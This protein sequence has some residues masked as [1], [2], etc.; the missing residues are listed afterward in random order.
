MND[1]NDPLDDII[2][3]HLRYLEGEGPA[4]VVSDLPE[5]LQVEATA[6]IALLDVSWGV[7]L[8]LPDDDPVARRF[9]FDR[10]GEEITVDGHRV[11]SHRRSAGLDLKSLLALVERAGGRIGPGELY[12]LEQNTATV[13]DQPTASALVAALNVA[14]IDI[15]SAGQDGN[16]RIRAFLAGPEFHYLVDDWAGTYG[17]DQIEVRNTVS[18]R[19]LAAQ[20]RAEDVTDDQ[21]IEIVRAILE[22][23]EP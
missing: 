18:R 17:Q 15:E 12:R 6:R 9:G 21:L 7:S 22:T 19:V 16:P 10:A 8:E 11:A 13:V 5:D 20:Y 14:L 2:D 23:L 4:P 3:S 1:I